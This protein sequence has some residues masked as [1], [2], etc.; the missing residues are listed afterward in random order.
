MRKSTVD[1]AVVSKRYKLITL[2]TL[3]VA[4]NLWISCPGTFSASGTGVCFKRFLSTECVCPSVTI[5]SLI[6]VKEKFKWLIRST[7][8]GKILH[9][10]SYSIT[11]L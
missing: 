11:V 5:L 4:T 10:T 6:Q 7:S 8:E 1:A 3:P 2:P 9:H